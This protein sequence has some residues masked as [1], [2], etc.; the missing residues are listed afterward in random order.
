[1]EKDKD[2]CYIALELALGTVEE[3]VK[4]KYTDPEIDNI[5]ILRQAS[6]GLEWLHKRKISKTPLYIRARRII[7]FTFFKFCI[8]DSF[9][10]SRLYYFSIRVVSAMQNRTFNLTCF[11]RFRR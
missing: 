4:G 11:L 7:L 9:V 6:N 5:S 10:T 3:F 1:M 8:P 2:F